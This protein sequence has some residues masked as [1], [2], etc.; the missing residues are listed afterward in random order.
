MKKGQVFLKNYS[1]DVYEQQ[2]E[3]SNINIDKK[4]INCTIDKIMVM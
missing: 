4:D 3:L 2:I 1:F